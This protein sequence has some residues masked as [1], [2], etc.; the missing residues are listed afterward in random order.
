MDGYLVTCYILRRRTRCLGCYSEEVNGMPD[1][2]INLTGNDVAM[3]SA[4]GWILPCS[5][6][7]PSEI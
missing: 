7:V 2:E 4:V 5:S 1:N 6:T 3:I